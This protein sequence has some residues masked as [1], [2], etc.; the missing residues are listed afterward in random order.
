MISALS[1]TRTQSLILNNVLAFSVFLVRYPVIDLHEDIS[2]YFLFHGG[3]QPLGDFSKDIDDRDADIPKYLR[4]N[5]KIV[6]AAMFPGIET[7]RL[8]ESRALEQLYGVWIPAI[9]YRAPQTWLL[10][11]F[12]IYYKLVDTYRELEVVET[13][14]QVEEILGGEN[15][16]GLILHLEG[17]EAIDD[18]YD[19]VLLMKLGLRSIGL[20]WNYDNKYGSG[21]STRKDRGLTADGEELIR[22]ANKLG[23]IVDLAH[24]SRR[25]ALE[26]IEVSK[27]PVI[28]SHANVRRFVDTPRNVDDEV[29]EALSRNGG[30]IGLSA[31]GPLISRKSRPTLDDL[32]QHFMYIYE[33]YGAD[34]LAIGT[35]FHGL[36][37]LP[38]PE[39]FESIDKVQTLLEKLRAAGL[40]DNDIRKIAYENA[41]RVLRANFVE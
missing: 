8:E 38:A 17:A 2:S 23:I 9:G 1:S 25:T 31:I 7:F 18:P 29:L 3:G 4:G 19:L 27:K 33:R 10:E 30:V 41:L 32:V 13:I 35:D 5:V 36:L 37:G 21:C 34:I 16:I 11:H 12:A 14:R 40:M 15:R 6:F 39:G 24:A 20:T 22:M 28:I 26:A